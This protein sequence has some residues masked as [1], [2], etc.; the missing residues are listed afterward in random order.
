MSLIATTDTSERAQRTSRARRIWSWVAI[1]AVI[2]ITGS[3]VYS[4]QPEWSAPDPLAADSLRYD[5][6]RAITTILEERGTTVTTADDADAA[7]AAL[8]SR[9]TLVI[10]DTRNLDIETLRELADDARETVI[11]DG[12]IASL[13]AVIPGI[14]YADAG[15]MDPIAPMCS[16]P[17]ADNAGRSSPERHIR[18]R[19]TPPAA[20]RSATATRSCARKRR[21]DPP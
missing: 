20:T 15:S 5:G 9:S 1:L 7:R 19:R 2:V 21:A 13:D 6:A 18:L 17:A 12:D 11:L 8:S 4:F 16:F 3:V 10:T 14:E